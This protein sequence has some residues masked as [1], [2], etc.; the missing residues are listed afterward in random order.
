MRTK[1]SGSSPVTFVNNAK[2]VFSDWNLSWPNTA[3]IEKM[4]KMHTTRKIASR[5]MA[6]PRLSFTAEPFGFQVLR[7]G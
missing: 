4:P 2:Y 1:F 6:P 5:Q 3:Y 7:Q